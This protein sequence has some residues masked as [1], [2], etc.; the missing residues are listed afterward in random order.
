MRLGRVIS[1]TNAKVIATI[2]WALPQ[3][4]VYVGLLTPFSSSLRFVAGSSRSTASGKSLHRDSKSNR[5]GLLL[6]DT[7]DQSSD[8][9][10][11]RPNNVQVH[12]LLRACYWYDA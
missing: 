7:A 12:D 8:P 3:A 9:S 6:R 4:D 2:Q 10:R 5:G 11:A 1:G